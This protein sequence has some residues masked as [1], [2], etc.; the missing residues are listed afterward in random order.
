MITVKITM[1]IYLLI[2]LAVDLCILVSNAK[3]L[4]EYMC[5]NNNRYK[6]GCIASIIVLAI[7]ALM[8]LYV[9]YEAIRYT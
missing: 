8:V 7:L 1:V 9:M 4:K 2:L 6:N 5:E 3:R